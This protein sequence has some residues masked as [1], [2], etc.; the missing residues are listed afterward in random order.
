MGN[1]ILN[2]VLNAREERWNLRCTLSE[3]YSCTIISTTICLPHLA[4]TAE[5]F[6]QFLHYSC[7]E[8]SVYLNEHDCKIIHTEKIDG[9]DGA[10]VFFCCDEDAIKVKKLTCDFEQKKAVYRIL[11]IDIMTSDGMAISRSNINLPPRKCFICDEDAAVCVA[12]RRHDSEEVS[13][14]VNEY[15]E[16]IRM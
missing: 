5:D 13:K 2:A 7:E 14:K 6:K 12:G 1:E 8:L 11:D 3:K 16:L 15:R 9:D 4:R 10:C